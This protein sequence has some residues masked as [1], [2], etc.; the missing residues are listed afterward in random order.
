VQCIITDGKSKQ[1]RFAAHKFRAA[2][3][4]WRK[5]EA[6]SN[7]QNSK[8]FLTYIKTFFADAQ[9]KLPAKRKK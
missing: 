3:D 8:L 9:S 4:S 1:R 6:D 2:S 5:H 7:Q